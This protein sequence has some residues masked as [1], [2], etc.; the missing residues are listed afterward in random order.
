MIIKKGNKE[1]KQEIAPWKLQFI[2]MCH[3]TYPAAF[4]YTAF[5]AD[6]HCKEALWCMEASGLRY[7]I[8]TTTSPRTA[9]D[10][11]LLRFVMMILYRLQQL[12]GGISFVVGQL[13]PW[14]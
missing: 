3:T 10:I 5:L 7:N 6:V 1:S 9:L 13:K 14:I 12:I 8:K 4:F 11:L 2:K